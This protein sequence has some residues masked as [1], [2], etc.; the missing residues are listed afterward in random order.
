MRINLQPPTPGIVSRGIALEGFCS[1]LAGIWGS[2]TGST[3][4]TENVHTINITK[5]AN[6]RAVQLGAVFLIFFSLIGKVLQ[7]PISLNCCQ[8]HKVMFYCC[9][10]LCF[11][12]DAVI[13]DNILHV[14]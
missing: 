6:R 14:S 2:G 5:V 13:I 10:K 11:V 9:V 8:K 12:L 7:N 1:I 4:L 3:T